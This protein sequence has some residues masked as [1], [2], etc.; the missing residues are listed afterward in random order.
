M[1]R[2]PDGIEAELQRLKAKDYPRTT[3]GTLDAMRDMT[4]VIY[5]D[6]PVQGKFEYRTA[7]LK[8]LQKY[9]RNQCGRTDQTDVVGALM[10]GIHLGDHLLRWF[11]GGRWEY[12][13]PAEPRHVFNL[14]LCWGGESDG[15]T[16]FPAKRVAK[17]S[18][19]PKDDFV[20]VYFTLKHRDEVIAALASAE[21]G[22]WVDMPDDLRVRHVD[23]D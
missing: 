5:P 20:S 17:F 11:R 7:Y 10:F 18:R 12:R 23:P 1:N 8:R 6:I 2:D 9:V 3:E 14:C 13:G 22:V 16:V 15:W 4:R 21:P 19:D